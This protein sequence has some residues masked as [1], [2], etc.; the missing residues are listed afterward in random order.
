MYLAKDAKSGYAIYT[1]EFDRH[2]PQR[3][4]LVADLRQAIDGSSWRCTISR[5][6]TCAPGA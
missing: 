6:S 1:P 5:R 3:L 4:A 2:S